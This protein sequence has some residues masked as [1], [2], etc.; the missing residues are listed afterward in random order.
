MPENKKSAE[1]KPQRIEK[2][3]VTIGRNVIKTKQALLD[4]DDK[5]KIVAETLDVLKLTY[6]DVSPDGKIIKKD[7]K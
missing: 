3:T 6:E 1:N 7:N 5:A 2:S 4:D